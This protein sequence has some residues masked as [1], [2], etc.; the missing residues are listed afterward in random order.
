MDITIIAGPAS[1]SLAEAVAAKLGRRL[2][3]CTV[4]RFADSEVHVEIHDSVRGHDVYLIQATSPPVDTH[5]IELLFLADACRRAGAAQ[6]TA[7]VPYFGYA[8]QDRR[9]PRRGA[10]REQWPATS[11]RRRPPYGR[12]GRVLPYPP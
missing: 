2:G 6:L 9:A 7:V 12:S 10:A 3:T 4:H 8:R 5:L 11:G 1:T